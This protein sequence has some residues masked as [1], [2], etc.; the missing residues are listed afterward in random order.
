MRST[1]PLF[2]KFWFR[3]GGPFPASAVRGTCPVQA[4]RTA[5]LKRQD[6]KPDKKRTRSKSLKKE[7]EKTERTQRI[8]EDSYP[9]EHLYDC[10]RLLISYRSWR[11][12]EKLSQR[13]KTVPKD[14][15]E[16]ML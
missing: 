2:A 12:P 5:A 8:G 6:V 4:A 10:Q 9:E 16:F 3:L 11:D 7:I 13:K 15:R 14:V 1:F